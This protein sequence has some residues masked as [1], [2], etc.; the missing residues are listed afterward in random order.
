MMKGIEASA[1][2][3]LP[4]TLL[5]STSEKGHVVKEQPEIQD[6]SKV[7]VLTKILSIPAGTLGKG[8]IMANVDDAVLRPT[9]MATPAPSK[10]SKDKAEELEMTIDEAAPPDLGKTGPS[11]S[12]PLEQ[13]FE[14]LLKRIALPIPEVAPLGDLKYIVRHASEKQLTGQQIA[15]VQ[16]YARDLKYPRGSLVYEGHD[17]DD[18]LYCLPNNKEIDV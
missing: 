11:K 10:I 18:Y 16:H 1:V 6:P 14:S 4:P 2:S 17:E 13:E 7:Q 8:K 15:E 3:A 9:K 12:K 5:E